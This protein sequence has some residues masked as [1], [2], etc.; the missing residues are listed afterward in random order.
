V[1]YIYA[2]VS[3][4]FGLEEDEAVLNGFARVY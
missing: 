4:L 2:N 1:G 3:T